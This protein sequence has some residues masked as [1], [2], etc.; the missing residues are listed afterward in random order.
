LATDGSVVHIRPLRADDEEALK[1]LNHRVSDRSI[2]LRFFALDRHGA[3]AQAHH[4]PGARTTTERKV[5]A[6]PLGDHHV[7][8]IAEVAGRTVDVGTFELI[9]A[10]AAEMAFLVDDAA[11]GRGIGTL[12]LELTDLLAD[13]RWCGLPLADLDPTE[14]VCI[15]AMRTPA[16]RIP[17]REAGGCP[18]G[19]GGAAPDCPA[20]RTPPRGL[21]AG[22]QPSRR[23]PAGAF[24]ID[25]K[26]RITPAVTEPAA[27]SRRLR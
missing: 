13:R 3:D 12:L 4:L 8:L 19:T 1:A 10:G 5:A 21:R 9:R 2:Y 26:V 27:Y 22:R 18:R 14:M 24:A 20:G 17:R 23:N 25:V 16:R 6:T 11:Q 7:A 15:A